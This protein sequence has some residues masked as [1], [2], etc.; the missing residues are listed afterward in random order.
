MLAFIIAPF[1]IAL[2]IFVFL[3]FVKYIKAYNI[4][5]LLV[6]NHIFALIMFGG[7]CFVV[8][9]FLLPQNV[10]FKR[11]FVQI[12]YYWFGFVLYFMV[13]LLICVI[14]R[15]IIWLFIK[16]KYDKVIARGLTSVFV[17]VF[18]I[19]MCT[20]GII[21]AHNLKITTYDI[22]SNKKSSL[23]KLNIVLISDL[24]IG[25]NDRLKEIQDM[26]NKINLLN[27]NV[28]LFAGDMF[29]NSYEAI[30]NPDE[31]SK[32]LNSINTKYGKYAIY[33]NHDTQEN[34]LMGFSFDWSKDLKP[35]ADE[36][37]I[38]FIEDSGFKLLYDSYALIE[39]SV[40]VYGR[41]DRQKINLGNNT[42]IEA[43]KIT[44]KLN[45]DKTIICLDHQP[46][47]L[48]ELARAGVDIDLCGHTH[49]GQ[50][51]PGTIT[52]DWFWKN[53]YGYQQ[54]ENMHSIVTSG[55]GLY[56]INMRTGCSAE[57]VNIN[58]KFNK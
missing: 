16:N 6:L 50:V 14:I 9:G 15:S 30:Q 12:G 53:A 29:D 55:V 31:I 49:N 20:Y 25:Y 44:E 40:Y 18:T 27:P 51:W 42:R 34:L 48:E 23:D 5:G 24:H 22:T 28:V 57:I 11:Y 41:P 33:G 32:L 39:N 37:M 47:E 13:G 17:I 36:R 2:L 52:I 1:F 10:G 4:K 7:L 56:G 8:T 54:I 38:K 19:T 3:R 43:S 58:L 21:N 35:E 46:A 45:I 26:V